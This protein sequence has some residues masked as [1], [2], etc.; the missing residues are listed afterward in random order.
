MQAFW[1]WFC[2][3]SSALALTESIELENDAVK[4]SI[5]CSWIWASLSQINRKDSI[6]ARTVSVAFHSIFFALCERGRGERERVCFNLNFAFIEHF[7]IKW[8]RRPNLILQITLSFSFCFFFS[9]Y[10]FARLLLCPFRRPGT[11]VFV[12]WATDFSGNRYWTAWGYST[13]SI[14]I[15]CP[16]RVCNLFSFGLIRGWSLHSTRWLLGPEYMSTGLSIAIEGWL[17]LF[18][19]K[20]KTCKKKNNLQKN[21]SY[22]DL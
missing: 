8:I 11:R 9:S 19:L 3:V 14:L 21:N 10:L 7:W 18:F 6:F 12:L 2:T 15:P 20:M 5:F 22:T 13:G 16:S 17:F 1:P 4:E